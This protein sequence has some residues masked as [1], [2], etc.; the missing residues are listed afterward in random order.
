M[1]ALSKENLYQVLLYYKFVEIPDPVAYR[2]EHFGLCQE[3]GLKGRILIA[4][5]G[6]NGT[7]S[8]TKEATDA[9]MNYML[10]HPYFEGIEFKVD[11]HYEH[12]FHKLH[13]RC[14]D[15]LVNLGAPFIPPAAPYIE[16]EEMLAILEEE[17][18]DVVIIDTRSDYEYNVGKFKNAIGFNIHHFRDIHAY[19]DEFEK[20]KDKK[21]VTY[22]T[23][24]I[25]CEKLTPLLLRRGFRNI[26]QLHG[27]IIRY[28]KETGGKHFEGQC[29]VFDDRVVVPVNFVNPSVIGRCGV[30]AAPTEKFVNCANADC[31][32]HFLLCPSC[33]ERLQGCC[34]EECMQAPKRRVYDGRGMYWRGVNSKNYVTT[35]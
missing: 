24:G 35:H 15:E 6:I 13:V 4:K 17:P 26:Y 14:K 30:C 31:N 27:G 5:E 10:N 1:E 19:L 18:E 7:V 20:Y 21:I 16:P 11:E 29:Y 2:D 34:S 32:K 12:A 8:G 25:R 28:S 22:C 23:G 9:Y 33:Q 3:L